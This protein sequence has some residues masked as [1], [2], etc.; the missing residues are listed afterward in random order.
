MWTLPI[1]PSGYI[2]RRSSYLNS[3]IPSYPSYYTK[4]E[5]GVIGGYCLGILHLMLISF[6]KDS[7]SYDFFTMSL[8]VFGPL[9]SVSGFSILSLM[10]PTSLVL[11]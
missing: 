6:V 3:F 2:P 7:L 8:T 10:T 9:A 4:G 11:G 1:S 5:V